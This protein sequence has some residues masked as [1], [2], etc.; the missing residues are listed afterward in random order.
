PESLRHARTRHVESI[1]MDVDV[2]DRQ[3]VESH[4]R[5]RR[6]R[7]RGESS[8]S[9]SDSEPIPHLDRSRTDARVQTAAAEYFLFVGTDQAIDPFNSS[10]KVRGVT[11]Q[12]IL[13]REAGHAT[14]DHP[15]R[16]RSEVRITGLE[17]NL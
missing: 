17:G 2:I 8:A 4:T 10:R 3:S 7:A 5:E 11:R 15:R 9:V 16:E 6:R 1:A 13:E 12:S 14:I